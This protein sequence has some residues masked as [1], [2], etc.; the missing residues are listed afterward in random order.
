MGNLIRIGVEGLGH[1]GVFPNVD[2]Y[3][4][5]IYYSMGIDTKMFTPIFAVSRIAG[6]VARIIE[7]L[8]DNSIFRPHA[9]YVG[10]RDLKYVP[11][12]ERI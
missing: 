8:E 3:S 11:V 5:L 1:K 4:G 7:Y 6:W 12:E 10:P 2:F 9:V